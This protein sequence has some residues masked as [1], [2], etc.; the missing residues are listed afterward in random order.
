[1][2]SISLVIISC[3]LFTNTF[4]EYQFISS[5]LNSES[6]IIDIKDSIINNNESFNFIFFN[7][8]CSGYISIFLK[9]SLAFIVGAI[10]GEK[11]YIKIVAY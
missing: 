1:M 10:A 4:K 5:N 9:L 2:F 3:A 11:K 6:S 8:D 7:I